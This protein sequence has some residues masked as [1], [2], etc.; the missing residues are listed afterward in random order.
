MIAFLR[1][2]FVNLTPAHVYIDV[3]GVGYE[4]HISLHTYSQ[5]QELK[6][7]T[8]FTHLLV[9]EDAHILYGFADEGEK[10]LFLKL[11]GVTGVGASTARMMLSY[12]KP[13]ELGRAIMNGDARQLERVKGIGRKTAERIVLEL[14]DKLIKNPIEAGTA[15]A[16][17]NSGWK[18]NTLETDALNALVALG[19]AR[20]AADAAV[21][22]VVAQNP[23]LGVEEVIKRALQSL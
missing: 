4:V 21:R 20:V 9:R 1:G 22:K 11:L 16:A 19:I 10:D 15:A 5:V 6:E 2:K 7:G 23:D 14:R 12:L 13:E 8:L 17:N 3:N 18:G